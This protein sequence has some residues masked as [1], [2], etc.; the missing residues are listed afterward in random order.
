MQK[1]QP[2]SLAKQP[3]SQPRASPMQPLR[4]DGLPVPANAGL[5]VLAGGTG[6]FGRGNLQVPVLAACRVPTTIP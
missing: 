6:L 3:G 1:V 5:S 4:C 2:W